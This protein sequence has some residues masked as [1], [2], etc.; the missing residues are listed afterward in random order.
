MPDCVSITIVCKE[1]DA[2]KFEKLGFQNAHDEYSAAGT[3]TLCDHEGVPDEGR[4]PDVPYVGSHGGHWDFDGRIFANIPQ[5]DGTFHFIDTELGV[6]GRPTFPLERRDDGA[7]H[8]STE[9]L[10]DTLGWI[11]QIDSFARQL[12]CEQIPG[13]D[14]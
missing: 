11:Q 10:N 7:L 12:G 9:D 2:P 3:V 4:W 1:S 8:I 14:L 5:A 13:L 6:N